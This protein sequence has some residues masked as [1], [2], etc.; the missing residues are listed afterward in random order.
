MDCRVAAALAARLG[1]AWHVRTLGASGFTATWR[2][3]GA[4]GPL[5]VKTLPAADAD[6]L[7]AEADGLQALAATTTVRVPA[8]AGCWIDDG[9]A[10]LALE[11]LEL[12]GS[13]DG[14]RLG[15]ALGA[16]HAAPAEGGGRFGWR[17]DN[18]LGSTVQ[19]NAWSSAGGL[20]GWIEFF[21]QRRLMAMHQ[22]LAAAGAPAALGHAVEAVVAALPRF[23]DDGHLPR[24][25][26]IHGDLWSGNHGALADGTPVVYDPAV[27]VSDAEAELAMLELFGSPPPGFWP[28]YRAT[29]GLAPGY[30]R[31][32]PLYQLH[33]LL[34]HALLFGGGYVAQSLRLAE[35]LSRTA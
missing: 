21:G 22:A 3:D 33:H 30:E 20:D 12:R 26:L 5:F 7:A 35:R 1:G 2:A 25:S 13:P 34:N 29:A 31:R 9:L 16:L 11:W 28:A 27:S 18:R 6:T 24:A 19:R 10:L 32:R 8:V 14:A 23:F 15:A 4:G 17:R